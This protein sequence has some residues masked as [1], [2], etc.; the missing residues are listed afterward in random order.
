MVAE[1][2]NTGKGSGRAVRGACSV[3]FGQ[4]LIWVWV[5][6]RVWGDGRRVARLD[7]NG[8]TRRALVR[9]WESRCAESES[10]FNDENSRTA[11]WFGGRRAARS[12]GCC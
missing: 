3:G 4:P 8:K 11:K 6:V 12:D 5:R 7:Q 2:L 1:A 10:V 9:P